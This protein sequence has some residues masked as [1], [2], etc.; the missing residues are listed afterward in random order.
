VIVPGLFF[1]ARGKHP[2]VEE[3]SREVPVDMHY[4]TM[5]Q[6]D[7]TYHLPPGMTLDGLPE[8]RNIEWTGRIGLSINVTSANGAVTIKRTFVRASALIDPSLY[9]SLRNI[10]QRISAADQQQIVLSRA[11]DA[12]AN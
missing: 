8:E 6:D 12:G 11:A 10:Y 1:E 5:E 4:A 3:E 7:V 9:S 2:F